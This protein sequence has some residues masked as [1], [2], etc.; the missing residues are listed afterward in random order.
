MVKRSFATILAL[1][2]ATLLVQYTGNGATP[3]TSTIQF[4]DVTRTSGIHFV[5]NNGAFG[6]KFLPETMGPGV[7][8]ID[9]DRAAW[10][11]MCLVIGMDW[12]GHVE[13]N[14]TPKLCHNSHD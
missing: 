14:S 10:P 12:P 5:H 13:K 8:C 11:D 3:E 4:R 1:A 2:L 9:C 7:A 6:K